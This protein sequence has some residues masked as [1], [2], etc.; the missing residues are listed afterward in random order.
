MFREKPKKKNEKILNYEWIRIIPLN[1][2]KHTKN[3]LVV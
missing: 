2:C 3:S 1:E